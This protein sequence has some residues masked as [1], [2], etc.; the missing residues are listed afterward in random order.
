MV[1]RSMERGVR[2]AWIIEDGSA[3]CRR[4]FQEPGLVEEESSELERKAQKRGC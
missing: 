1:P 2:V 4:A 3:K